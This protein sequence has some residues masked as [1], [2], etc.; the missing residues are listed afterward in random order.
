MTFRT[1]LSSALALA[2]ALLTLAPGA[3][4]QDRTTDSADDLAAEAPERM[5]YSGLLTDAAGTPL[6]DGPRALV[7]KAYASAEDARS[8]AAPAWEEATRPPSSAAGSSSSSARR[9][10]SPPTPPG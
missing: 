7:F 3:L 1:T 5:T 2:L 10:P 4:A 6:A 8:G 9:P